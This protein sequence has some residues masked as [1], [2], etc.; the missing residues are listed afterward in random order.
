MDTK[1][2]KQV[3]SA[4]AGA[5]DPVLRKLAQ[6]LASSVPENSLIRNI[7]FETALGILKGFIEAASEDLPLAAWLSLEKATD[8]ADFFAG[9][10]G[11]GNHQKEISGWME[12]FFDEA[13]E[14]IKTAEDPR[15]EIERI[16]LEF[17][18]RKELL[19]RIGPKVKADLPDQTKTR[20]QTLFQKLQA[21]Y[22][23][24]IE[25]LEKTATGAENW[26]K[27]KR[28]KRGYKS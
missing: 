28:R 6:E 10:L 27:A 2:K 12:K 18:L 20:W 19:E 25:S 4:A 22:Q 7:G 26:A 1:R 3:F 16:N 15:T 5:L 9:A 14:R 23:S 13:G 11:A 24:K 21:V 17:D 8:L